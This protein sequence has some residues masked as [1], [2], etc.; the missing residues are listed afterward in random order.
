[1]LAPSDL[2]AI[3]ARR[4]IGLRELSPVELLESCISRIENANP[5]LNA[6]VAADFAVARR[7]ARHAEAAVLRGGNLGRLH[8][9]P[10]AIK[11][12]CD[13]AGLRT[14]YGSLVFQDHVPA[15]DD[16]VVANLRGEGAIIVG[17]T[18]TPEFGAGGTTVN[19]VY[20]VTRNPFDS[21][22]T[23]GGSSGGSAVAVAAGMSTV[24]TGSDTGGS[25]RIP[26]S[27]CGVVAYRPTP[28]LIPSTANRVGWTAFGTQGPIARTVA[29]CALVL[30]VMASRKAGARVD[31]PSEAC[32]G[33]EECDPVLAG[34]RVSFSEDLGFAAVSDVIRMGFRAR[35]E[36]LQRMFARAES[37]DPELG[38]ASRAF[39]ILRT[40]HLASAHYRHYLERPELLG[41]NLTSAI[42]A[43]LKWSEEEVGWAVTEQQRIVS[44]F[45]RF[46]REYDLLISPATAVPPFPVGL[47]YCSEVDG[48][49]LASYTDWLS[50]AYGLSLSEAPVC[51]LP[52]GLDMTGMPFGL[53]I[54]SKRGCDR[55]LLR[56]AAAI[57]ACLAATPRLSRPRPFVAS[58]E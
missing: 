16:P 35:M 27:F 12:L 18:N 17:K 15:A 33:G 32:F 6:I 14:T 9:I 21:T 38:E 47:P 37:A 43:G 34:L 57:E 24:A 42:E 45:E 36:V 5:I 44:R 11:D 56:A 8:G 7:E 26:A 48:Q 55:F 52:C 49:A 31:N 2:S 28:G 30:S 20:G 13:T 22:R 29:D 41:Q 39:W 54:V 58:V 19:R 1:M 46:M 53:Q 25:L 50:I 40:S 23:C 3:E 10:V 51:L 4:L